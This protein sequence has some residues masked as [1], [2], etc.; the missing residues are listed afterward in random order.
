MTE[1]VP[2]EGVVSEPAPYRGI[3][4]FLEEYV[5]RGGLPYFNGKAEIGNGYT[6]YT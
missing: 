6:S 3:F 1:A 4:L 2:E 5:L